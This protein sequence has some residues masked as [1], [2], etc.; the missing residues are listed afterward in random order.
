MVLYGDFIFT[1]IFRFI[2]VI[3]SFVFVI[4]WLTNLK[5]NHSENHLNKE[6]VLD[7][8]HL[9]EDVSEIDSEFGDVGESIVNEKKEVNGLFGNLSDDFKDESTHF[10]K[11]HS[12][13]DITSFDEGI[14]VL[15]GNLERN[16]SEFSNSISSEDELVEELP[17]ILD[18]GMKDLA[19]RNSDV[20]SEVFK[21]IT[22]FAK[23]EIKKVKKINPGKKK[24]NKF[25]K[26]IG[27]VKSLKNSY[28]NFEKDFIK[29]SSVHKKK[30][31]DFKKRVE[32]NKFFEEES[33]KII[34]SI[35]S[36]NFSLVSKMDKALSNSLD[37]II[38]DLSNLINLMNDDFKRSN[39]KNIES[40]KHS[41]D[42]NYKRFVSLQNY[43]DLYRVK[44]KSYSFLLNTLISVSEKKLFDGFDMFKFNRFLIKERYDHALIYGND[45]KDLIS[46]IDKYGEYFLN[47]YSFIIEDVERLLKDDDVSFIEEYSAKLSKEIVVKLNKLVNVFSVVKDALSYKN[48]LSDDKR[49]QFSIPHVVKD[50][51]KYYYD[52]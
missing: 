50:L 51:E 2:L 31:L 22:S 30:L 46:V 45:A 47:Q 38:S 12:E 6:L 17:I 49:G 42:L 20:D 1:E 7:E 26:L 21:E 11:N 18:K 8:V 34:N 35:E 9:R 23:E 27:S 40:R 4:Y 10:K 41:F 13:S 37:K 14:S 43:F 3:L 15:F 5:L 16:F 48:F 39:Y 52:L 29:I 33:R 28:L 25:K 24:K 19:N 44:C 36:H 32:K